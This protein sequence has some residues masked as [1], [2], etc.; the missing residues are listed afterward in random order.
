MEVTPSPGHSAGHGDPLVWER[1]STAIDDRQRGGFPKIGADLRMKFFI[2]L[3]SNAM[4]KPKFV[5]TVSENVLLL[6]RVF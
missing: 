6:S 5:A 1:R 4:T 2:L 3:S